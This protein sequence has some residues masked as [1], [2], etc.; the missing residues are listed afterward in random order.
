M[1]KLF[2]IAALL[3][4]TTAAADAQS[5]GAG[6]GSRTTGAV[7]SSGSSRPLHSAKKRVTVRGKKGQKRVVTRTVPLQEDKTYHWKDGQR[8]TPTGHEAVGVNEGGA[9][10]KPR[11]DSLQGPRPR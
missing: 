9:V 1:K 2:W 7:S 3:L 5:S 6:T 8:A 11:K 10:A 4:G